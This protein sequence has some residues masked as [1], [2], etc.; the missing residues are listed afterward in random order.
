MSRACSSCCGACART[1]R[2]DC[3]ASARCTTPASAGTPRWCACCCAS[4]RTRGWRLRC[5]RMRAW[6]RPAPAADA[7]GARPAAAVRDVAASGRLLRQRRVRGGRDRR[8][9]ASRPRQR[10]KSARPRRGGPT[11]RALTRLWSTVRRTATRRCWLPRSAASRPWCRGCCSAAPTPLQP[12]ASASRHWTWLPARPPSERARAVGRGASAS[13]PA[14]AHPAPRGSGTAAR[15]LGDAA[16]RRA[17]GHVVYAQP[18]R[19]GEGGAQ[20]LQT[21]RGGRPEVRRRPPRGRA[22]ALAHCPAALAPPP[23]A[24]LRSLHPVR[25]ARRLP[26]PPRAGP[27]CGWPAAWDR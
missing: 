18:A 2:A 21:A 19:R 3:E 25:W 9:R 20:L 11:A 7:A 22:A 6:M 27:R 1:V 4:A 16:D 15:V 8:R 17:A 13:A 10:G 5:V 23:P 14:L 12:I 26:A 24:P